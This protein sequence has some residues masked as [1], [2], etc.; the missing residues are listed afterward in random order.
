MEPVPQQAALPFWKNL[1]AGGG[2]GLMEIACMY[3]TDVSCSAVLVVCTSLRSFCV[4]HHV[5]RF[6]YFLV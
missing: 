1:V 3:P 5:F 6:F 4:L 2:A